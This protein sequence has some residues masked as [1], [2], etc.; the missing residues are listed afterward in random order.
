VMQC[1][2]RSHPRAPRCST[3]RC[4]LHSALCKIPSR[5]YRQQQLQQTAGEVKDHFIHGGL[6][7]SSLK[8]VTRQPHRFLQCL[9]LT[10][11]GHCRVSVICCVRCW[12]L[13]VPRAGFPLRLGVLAGE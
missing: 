9:L 12:S 1:L 13:Q 6:F 8:S 2:E 3:S 10:T 11:H 5:N 4:A 7:K